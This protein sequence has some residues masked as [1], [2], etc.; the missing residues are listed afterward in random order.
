MDENNDICHLLP[1]ITEDIFTM[2][3]AGQQQGWHISSYNLPEVWKIS[4]GENVTIAVIDSG[5]DLTHQDLIE[6]LVPGINF[7]EEGMPPEDSGN[8]GCVSPD[9]L[10]Q[11]NLHGIQTIEELYDIIDSEEK[12]IDHKDGMYFVKK[13]D[14]LKTFS[15]DPNTQKTVLGEIE[16]IQKLYVKSDIIKITLKGNIEYK[17]TPWHPV[18]LL[19]NRHHNIYDVIRKRADEVTS[20]D[21]FIFGIGSELN[22]ELSIT[23]PERYICSSCGHRPKYWIGKEPSKC[24]KCQKIAWNTYSD[25]IKIN[26]DMAYLCGIVLTDGH[27]Q[28]GSGR[29][30]VTS[31][32]NEILEKIADISQRNNWH[33]KIEDKRILVYGMKSVNLLI[34]LGVCTGRKSLVQSL[35][36]WVGKAPA[37]LIGAFLAGVIDG[38]GCVSRKNTSNRIITGS[39]DFAKKT[40]AL[41]NSIGISSSYGKPIY[42]SRKRRISSSNPVYHVTFSAVTDLISKHLSHPKKILRSKIKPIGVR[43]SR[44]VKSIERIKYDGWFYDFTVKNYHNYIANGHFVSNTHV[45]GIIAANNNN[46]GMVGVAPKSKIMPIKVLNSF[47]MGSISTVAKA[48]RW[49]VDNGADLITMSLGARNPTPDVLDAINYANSKKVVCFVAAGN[50]GSTKQLLYPAA[51]SECISVGSI[52]E[53]S[54]RAD[55][56]C[57]GPNLDFVAPG[58]K[59]YSTVPTNSYAFLSGTCLAEGSYVYTPYGPQEIQKIKQGD[60]VYAWKNGEIVQ[61]TVTHNHYRGRNHVQKIVCA[62]RDLLATETHKLLSVN[63]KSKEIEWVQV[64]ELTDNHKLIL[65][66]EL[67]TVKNEYLDSILDQ[68]FCWLLGFFIGDGWIS[69]T[70]NGRRVN[71][72]TGIYPEID[73]KVKKIYFENTGKNLKESSKRWIYDD[74]TKTAMILECLGLNKYAGY[75]TFPNWVWQLNKDK[76]YQIFMGYYSAD[77]WDIKAKHK[78][79]GFESKSTDLIRKTMILAEYMGWSHSS[80]QERYRISKAP[81]SKN[82]ILAYSAG[83]TVTHKHINGWSELKMFSTSGGDVAKKMGLNPETT[84]CASWY[85]K[86][87]IADQN[88][89]DLTVPDAD[90]FVTN[91]IIT[92]NSMSC[93]FV[94]GVAALVLSERKTIVPNAK[95]SI[96]EYREILKSNALD[97]KNLDAKLDQ[98]GKRFWQG[99]G[100]INP[101]KFE[102]WVH[103]RTIDEIKKEFLIINDKL[104]MIKNK[105]L[106]QSLKEHYLLLGSKILNN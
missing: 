70:R 77:G 54:M 63:V 69:D 91:G 58:V 18:Y 92:H 46:D 85:K 13:K 34:K 105:D 38:D 97:I 76:I 44:K 72:A 25:E 61:R 67:D 19:E 51:Y 103:Y 11:T 73:D 99:V 33:Y 40:T 9:C 39:L 79:F 45:A 43:K 27:I 55:F 17:L 35:P 2:Q 98:Q 93:P 71:F 65:P 15:Y 42:D 101:S 3:S 29:F 80:I 60:L 36:E 21:N 66:R 48:I 5:C 88:V 57:T 87:T 94:V 83:T 104:T 41:L 49:A 81:N 20:E 37:N 52:D 74:S 12:E 26:E 30:E 53:N 31:I 59:I 50:A 24:K 23:M 28:V 8:H 90:C 95:I 84:F 16:S 47:G 100:I 6:N 78:K 102:E 1:Y 10:I 56:S 4:Q 32:T 7:V 68:E 106:L 62:G 75:K 96:D 82:A 22:E 14:G 89:Y 64:N 86:E